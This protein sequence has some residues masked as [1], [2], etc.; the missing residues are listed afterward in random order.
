MRPGESV[1]LVVG[2]QTAAGAASTGKVLAD[3]TIVWKKN[4][5]TTAITTTCT[6]V[7]T[8]GG[9][10]EY[11]FAFTLPTGGPYS[12]HGR[13][14]PASG[15]DVISGGIIDGEI[16]AQD[17]DSLAALLPVIPVAQL[18]PTTRMADPQVLRLIAKRW[19]PISYTVRDSAGAAVPLDT[20]NNWR[21]SVWDR[22]HASTI[23]TLSSGIT[24]SALGVAAWEIPETA[25]FYTQI[26][27]AIAAGTDP[28]TLYWD[29]VADNAATAAKSQSV[30]SGTVI[31][32]R[33]ESP[34]T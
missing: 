22:L 11:R 12:F 19:Y 13:I 8:V 30:L 25:S 1:T 9:W 31:L 27:A 26:D 10:R 21:F 24:G 14:V 29:L 33:Y 18:S 15:T 3:F 2:R 20:Y 7:D 17:L 5:V 4:G 28:L 32:S 6:E 34:A 16:E 23:Y